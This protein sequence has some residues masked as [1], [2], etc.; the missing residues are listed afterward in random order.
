[1]HYALIIIYLTLKIMYAKMQYALK[2]M[3]IK[4]QRI[5]DGS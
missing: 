4:K 3:Q 5:K 1:M 2:M